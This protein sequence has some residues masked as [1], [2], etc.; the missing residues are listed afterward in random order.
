[1][2]LVPGNGSFNAP[3]AQPHVL[4]KGGGVQ[5]INDGVSAC[6]QQAKEKEAVI[7]VLWHLLDHGRMEPVPQAQEVVRGPA[8]DE[9]GNNHYGHLESLH[10][11]LGDVVILS[12]Y[13]TC[14]RESKGQLNMGENQNTTIH[15]WASARNGRPS[16]GLVCSPLEAKRRVKQPVSNP[17]FGLPFKGRWQRSSNAPG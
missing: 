8:D 4:P 11:C 7:D 9:G 12:C 13:Q 15:G 1:M 17:S 6:V 10:A 3:E 2:L 16:Q 14:Q 5:P